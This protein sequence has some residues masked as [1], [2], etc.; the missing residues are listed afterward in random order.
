MHMESVAPSVHLGTKVAGKGTDVLARA[1]GAKVLL[2]PILEDTVHLASRAHGNLRWRHHTELRRAL[3]TSRRREGRRR[4]SG[5]RTNAL[6]SSRPLTHLAH[7]DIISTLLLIT[8]VPTLVAV[9]DVL[10]Q[11]RLHPLLLH[12]P[13]RRRLLH[14]VTIDNQSTAPRGTTRRH[15]LH[16]RTLY[17]R[18]LRS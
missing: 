7:S 14:R 12:S 4:R 6:A 16:H 15:H 5:T 18:L 8:V 1:C 9:R 11:S 13:A 2:K 10:L 17:C 3:P